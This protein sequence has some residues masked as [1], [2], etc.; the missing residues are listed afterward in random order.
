MSTVEVVG[1]DADWKKEVKKEIGELNRKFDKLMSTLQNGPQNQQQGNQQGQRTHEVN[2][3][4]GQG[5]KHVNAVETE[6]RKVTEED[7]VEKEGESK[8]KESKEKSEESDQVKEDKE[9]ALEDMKILQEMC[10]K[11]KAPTP[12]MVRLTVKAS[13]ALL[14]TL[15][16]KERDH[17]SP[18]MTV[19]EGD[20]I[21]RNTLL[22]LEASV[23]VLPGYLYDNYK[24]EELE[25]AKTYESLEDAP[26]LILGRPFLATA[27]AVMDCKTGDMDISFGTR[28]RRLNMF[29]C[30][31]SLPPGYD[32]KYL[33][34]R[35]LMAPREK[36]KGR[37][38]V[39]GNGI[40]EE[41]ILW[42]AKRH[43]LATV[44][45]M[46]LLDILEMM[47][48][49]HQQY[50]KDTRCREAK[51]FQILDAQQQWI[52]QVSD[53]MTQRTTLLATLVHDF[54]P[55]M[56]RMMPSEEREE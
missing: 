40:D 15:P 55:A 9:N 24:N 41:E 28:K 49:K 47:E 29:G 2:Q 10:R 27:G 52:S 21:I 39:Q 31:I 8:T 42:E 5:K 1:A 26:A 20:V 54:A 51:V 12:D 34:N 50:E 4:H 45:K 35:P 25:P 33:N 14:G 3:V 18:L 19:T 46:Q 43:P 6:W 13:E 36:D 44:D 56:K 37:N 38:Q 53:R 17:G 23:N 32:D 22:D 16:K 30:P 48:L 11:N 7:L